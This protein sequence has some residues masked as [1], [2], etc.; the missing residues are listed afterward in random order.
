MMRTVLHISTKINNRMS[1]RVAQRSS[2]KGGS[3]QFEEFEVDMNSDV[4]L[5]TFVLLR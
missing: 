5:G 4:Y 3:F 2:T 1:F